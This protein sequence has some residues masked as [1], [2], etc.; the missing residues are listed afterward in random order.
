M[1]KN[2]FN[3]SARNPNIHQQDG[4]SLETKPRI[5]IVDDDEG[6]VAVLRDGFEA[7]GWT[8]CVAP[9]GAQALVIMSFEK[10]D[11]VMSDLHMPKMNGL[12]LLYKI[13][14]KENNR[15]T[16]FCL[17]SGMLNQEDLKKATSL[18]VA[19]VVVKP[20]AIK[21]V[22]KKVREVCVLTEAKVKL[23][24]DTSIIRSIINATEEVCNFYFGES[25]QF[26]KP[27]IK[28]DKSGSGCLSAVISLSRHEALGSVAF[29]C[30]G[31]FFRHLCSKLFGENMAG[32]KSDM[33]RDMGGE[34]CNQ[35]T[36]KIK[37]NLSRNSYHILIGLPQ[38][39]M[40][41]GHNIEHLV[42]SPVLRIPMIC[43]GCELAIE[44]AM[45]GNLR[46]EHDHPE[47]SDNQSMRSDVMLFD[48]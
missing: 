24:Y 3:P 41:K 14:T 32:V 27:H 34:I 23:S 22:T 35:I 36:G 15:S 10:F 4:H 7:D 25:V 48:S 1:M 12:E 42:N 6:I 8:V 31:L 45:S 13:K 46:E 30:D 11:A 18:G 26:G 2:Q 21:A 20:F 19:H 47:G 33:I 16:K 9:D 17:L 44:F 29:S 5:L 43:K 40:G 38:V 37:I 28:T 39:I